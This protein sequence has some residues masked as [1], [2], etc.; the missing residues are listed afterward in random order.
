MTKPEVQIRPVAADDLPAIVRIQTQSPETAQW[1]PESYLE[2]VSSVAVI[3]GKIVGF[4][5][6]RTLTGLEH[7]VLNI[8]VA[9]EWRRRGIA[10]CLIKKALSE[11]AGS[12]FLEVRAS[13]APALRFYRSMGFQVAG[14]RKHYYGHPRESAI[15]MRFQSC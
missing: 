1:T 10:K 6:V 11:L 9:P 8:A 13:N 3:D 14:E 4:L 2:A 12:V 15:V 7:E 5:A